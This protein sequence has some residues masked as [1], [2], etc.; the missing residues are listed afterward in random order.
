MINLA[1][2]HESI[3]S[4]ALA[5]NDYAIRMLEIMRIKPESR[6]P[7]QAQD[8]AIMYSDIIEAIEAEDENG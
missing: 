6:T 1:Q 5:G 2:L 8:L 7:E 4:A 3:A